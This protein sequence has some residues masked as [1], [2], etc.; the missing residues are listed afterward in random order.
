MSTAKIEEHEM[1]KFQYDIVA[2]DEPNEWTEGNKQN[3][4]VLR[5]ET[6]QQT[7]FGIK[8][9]LIEVNEEYYVR[10][11]GIGNGIGSYN[12]NKLNVTNGKRQST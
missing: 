4:K 5:G 7:G 2:T 10:M 1:V 9:C 8:K 6:K 3:N 11:I 12:K